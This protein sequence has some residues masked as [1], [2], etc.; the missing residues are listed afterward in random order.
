MT[1]TLTNEGLAGICN[2]SFEL[3]HYAIDLARYYMK[4]GQEMS[5]GEILR[6]VKRH[7]NPK[8]LET[9]KQIDALEDEEE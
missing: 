5:I 9:L 1:D 6:E 7:P 8:Y 4:S 3:A 2:S